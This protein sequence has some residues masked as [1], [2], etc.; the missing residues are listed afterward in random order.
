MKQEIVVPTEVYSRVAGYFRPVGHWNTGK[1]EE[2]GA[3]AGLQFEPSS[4]ASER[5]L[6]EAR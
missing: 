6:A 5:E 1:Q 2:F 3:R 4:L